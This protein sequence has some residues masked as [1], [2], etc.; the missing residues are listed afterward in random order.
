MKE[1]SKMKNLINKV[2][3]INIEGL[4]LEGLQSAAKTVQDFMPM[5]R[6]T[7]NSEL[8]AAAQAKLKEIEEAMDRIFDKK[9]ETF[10]KAESQEE[11]VEL[12]EAEEATEEATEAPKRDLM[13]IID[14]IKKTSIE[15]LELVKK[16]LLNQ[17]E[18]INDQIRAGAVDEEIGY[19]KLKNILKELKFINCRLN[20]DSWETI[21]QKACKEVLDTAI[22]EAKKRFDK[23]YLIALHQNDIGGC[24]PGK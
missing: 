13:K 20:G 22:K 14:D 6:A 9:F 15:G 4:N 16:D 5:F 18:I 12:V 23:R 19:K 2:N 10:R 8:I 21:N 17:K 3:K 11:L 24:S 1:E 7:E